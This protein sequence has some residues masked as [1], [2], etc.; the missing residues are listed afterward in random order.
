MFL[1]NVGIYYTAQQPRRPA[2]ALHKMS[3]ISIVMLKYKL[4]QPGR[5]PCAL[6]KMSVISISH[7]KI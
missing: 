2:S 5:P 4:Q 7:V 3:V 6:H 1:R